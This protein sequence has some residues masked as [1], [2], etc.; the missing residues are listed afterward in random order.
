M[1]EE[2]LKQYASFQPPNFVVLPLPQDLAVDKSCDEN[3]AGDRL[4]NYLNNASFNSKRCN[5]GVSGSTSPAI[6]DELWPYFTMSAPME[7]TA[8]SCEPVPPEQPMAPIILPFSI[9]GKPPPLVV[10]I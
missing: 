10:A 3:G 9:S 5:V 2:K 1:G 4:G 7:Q 8:A 6:P